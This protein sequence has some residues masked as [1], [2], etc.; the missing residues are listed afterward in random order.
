AVG[1]GA[2]YCDG[3]VDLAVATTGSYGLSVLLGNGDGTCQELQI[4]GAGSGPVAVASGDFNRDGVPDL[5]VA[6][7]Y[8]NNVSVLVGRKTND[9]TTTGT[10][11]ETG[12]GSPTSM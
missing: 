1:T 4:F 2:F 9:L 3:R 10:T 7:F 5:A 12:S 6:N 8:S 11:P